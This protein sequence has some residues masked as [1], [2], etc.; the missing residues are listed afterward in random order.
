MSHAARYVRPRCIALGGD[1]LGNVVES[2][3]GI[4]H[5]PIVREDLGHVD[6]EILIRS[7]HIPHEFP[8]EVLDQARS[9]PGTI[10]E[11]EIS[12]RR[13]FRALDIEAFLN[14]YEKTGA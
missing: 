11:G 9:I 5:P 8:D 13:D 1:E 6:V 10:P 3:D 2:D 7:H 4:Q 12:K 14:K